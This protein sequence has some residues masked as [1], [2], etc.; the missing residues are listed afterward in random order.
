M[1]PKAV[2]CGS[3]HREPA[4]LKRLFLELETTG[5]RVLAPVNL[6]FTE[7]DSSIVKANSETR[8]TTNELESSFL[9]AI[10]EADFLLLHAPDGYVGT[11]G[12]YE[13]GYA[14]ALNVPRFS[15]ERPADEML[16]SRVRVAH[17]VF[18]ILEQ[19]QLISF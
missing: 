8:L 14:E 9:Q 18:D 5:C 16:A 2:L 10:H 6:N 12:A 15:I 11:A 17:S 13:L 4:K 1:R 3:Y 19:L 7:L